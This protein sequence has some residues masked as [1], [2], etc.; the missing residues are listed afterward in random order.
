[1]NCLTTPLAIHLSHRTNCSEDRAAIKLTAES[2]G[3]P[4]GLHRRGPEGPA[5]CR[6][7]A[8]AVGDTEPDVCSLSARPHTWAGVRR[9][10]RAPVPPPSPQPTAHRG[11]RADGRRAAPR[12]TERARGWPGKAAARGEA[13]PLQ[14]HLRRGHLLPQ[15]LQTHPLTCPLP[16]TVF[17]ALRKHS[18]TPKSQ[19]RFHV[20]PHSGTG[21]L[22]VPWGCPLPRDPS[23]LQHMSGL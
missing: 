5:G 22:T 13:S 6:A 8:S 23:G 15:A 10:A 9:G 7:W 20:C 12:P 1:M 19:I 11:G 17:R 21:V 4:G 2:K 14:G 18:R 3:L 16:I